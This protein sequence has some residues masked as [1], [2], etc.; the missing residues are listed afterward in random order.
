MIFH[1]IAK[2][3][4]RDFGP[5]AC[6]VRI[7]SIH[8]EVDNED[9]YKDQSCELGELRAYFDPTAWNTKKYGLIYTDPLWIREFMQQ[10]K[11]LGF[12]EAARAEV[13]YS[14]KGMQGDDYVSMDV[15]EAFVAE[16]V[17]KNA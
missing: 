17:K 16:W 8:V 2:L 3:A 12:S 14:E 1:S 10:L 9:Y 13:C 4:A 5:R 7:D 11:K 6:P 15:G